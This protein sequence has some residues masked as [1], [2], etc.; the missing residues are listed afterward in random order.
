MRV[1]L[2]H[3][4]DEYKPLEHSVFVGTGGSG[5][6][7]YVWAELHKN[8]GADDFKLSVHTSDGY[9]QIDCYYLASTE[10]S[11]E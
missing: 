9:A 10:P 7:V 6:D 4:P 3:I 8:G 2:S 5:Y 1:I 11:N